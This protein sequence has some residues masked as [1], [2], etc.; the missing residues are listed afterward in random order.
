MTLV[1]R[2][3]AAGDTHDLRRRVLRDDDPNAEL[4]WPGDH[5]ATTVHLGVSTLDGTLVGVSTWLI[6]RD[7]LAPDVV[8]VQLRGMA[9]D[10]D[11]AGRGVGTMLLAAGQEHVRSIGAERLWA[12]ARVTAL[13][14][15][16][17]AGFIAQGHEFV[18]PTTGLL[19]R[20][21]H[22]PTSA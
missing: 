5:A 15:Y 4:D 3:I 7:P 17:R 11:M 21:V 19:H 13:G 14:F 6:E 18:T 8:A 22:L 10:P 20:H 2:K 16:E 12:N 9:T 1:A